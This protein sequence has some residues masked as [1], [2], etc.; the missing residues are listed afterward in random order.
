MLRSFCVALAAFMALMVGE[1]HAERHALLIGV[2]DY[3]NPN[4]RDL[5]GPRNDVTMMW[6]LLKTQSFKP[7][8][9]NVVSDI[10]TEGTDYPKASALPTHAAILAALDA[11]KQKANQGDFIVIYFSGHG[12]DQP[13]VPGDAEPE[14]EANGV[15]QVLLPRDAG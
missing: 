3:D 4:I 13:D 12:T 7:E 6:R 8:N 10:V 14:P 1:A 9:I 2:S 15:D 11:L 5:H